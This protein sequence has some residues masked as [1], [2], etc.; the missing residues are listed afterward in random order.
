M[1]ITSSIVV[2]FLRF[3]LFLLFLYYLNRKF[4]NKSDSNNFLEFIIH[5]WYRYGSITAIVLFLMIQ[6]GIYDL[7]NLLVILLVIVFLDY[8]G[9]KNIRHIKTYIHTGTKNLLRVLIKRVELRRPL[10]IWLDYKHKKSI[11]GR[12]YY[13][14]FLCGTLAIITFM[15]RYYFFKYDQYTLSSLW[16][17][18]LQKVHDFDLQIWFLN[19]V[20]VNGS[21]AFAN[22]YGKMT[23]VSPEIALTSL[24]LLEATFMSVIIFW[25][26]RKLT[27]PGMLAPVI[28]TL[29]FA[30]AF[31]L[32][33]VNIYFF[34]QHKPVFLAMT[35]AFPAMLYMVRPG[36]LKF[37]RHNYFFA[38]AICFIAIGLINIFALF[39]LIP[40]F[41]IIAGLFVKAKSRSYYL[42]GFLSYLAA[43]LIILGLYA[44]I[45]GYFEIDFVAFMHKNLLSVSSYTYVPQLVIPFDNLV[46]YYQLLSFSGLLLLIVYA[47][48]L[49]EVWRP[50]VAFLLYFNVL[51]FISTVP[52]PWID[53]DLLNEALTVF[54]PVV[55]GIVLA[56]VLRLV[57]PLSE[58]FSRFN[59]VAA[60]TCCG[61]LLFAG[62]YFQRPALAQLD[63]SAAR[64]RQILDAYDHISSEYFP[65]S[66]AVVNDNY[67]Q[68]ISTHKHFFMNYSDFLYDYPS[69]DSIYFAHRKTPDFF[70][71]NP[72]H[73]LPK[74]ILL[75]VYHGDE[76]DVYGED[77][78]ISELLMNQIKMFRKRGRKVQLVYDKKSL[79]VYEIINEPRQSRVSDLIF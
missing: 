34:L 9:L 45:C 78:D 31:T 43:A 12:R 47:I 65:Y 70:K 67:T 54:M 40:P 3:S 13:I 33:P 60:G 37:K 64:S 16:L 35:L 6:F 8:A 62:V 19:E 29:S 25:L 76:E 48:F 14:F 51:I 17:F 38:Q 74:S 57:K 46:L 53:A 73:V 5:N 20:M 30:L 79:K 1:Q 66:Y 27:F 24:G 63:P 71:K 61:I 44:I 4:V 18:E 36:S 39:I 56:A 49:K 52:S 69:R 32:I 10:W 41:V 55:L 58:R 28:A 42:L 2:G 50:A 68:V 75:F 59:Y 15:A 11:N 7:L 21:L 22:L 23:Q 72:Q 77:G 26:I